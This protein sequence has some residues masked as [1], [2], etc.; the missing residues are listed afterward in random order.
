MKENGKMIKLVDMVSTNITMVRA[1]KGIGLMIINMERELK[2]G[3]IIA[4]MLAIIN[5]VKNMEKES[6]YGK[7]AVTMMEIGFKI[8]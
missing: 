7:M 8:K 5:K 6:I 4:H 1:T 2:L 3:L